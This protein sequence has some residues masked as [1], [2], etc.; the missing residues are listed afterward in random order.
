MQ[1]MALWG[2]LCVALA[3][4]LS[5]CGTK[6][7]NY[8]PSL[9]TAEEAIRQGLDA[10][11][12]GKPAGEVPGTKPM[13]YVTDTGRKPDQTLQS[14]Q[15]LGE[16]RGSTGR[17][18]AVTLQLTNPAEEIRT[19]Y[20]VVGIDPLWVFRQEDYELLTHWDHRM[21]A[22]NEAPATSNAG[23]VENETTPAV[24]LKSKNLDEE[25]GAAFE[26]P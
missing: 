6:T 16:T 24:E 12:N 2:C 9:A 4:G 22:T 21:P 3:S 14:Y 13:I 8:T 1:S 7:P 19:R 10:W 18:F 20:L 17:T 5:G 11:K 23:P 26:K 15:I 25:S